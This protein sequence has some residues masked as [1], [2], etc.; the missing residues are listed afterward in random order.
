M[1]T[2]YSANANLFSL[3]LED[4]H[5]IR[6]PAIKLPFMTE[7]TAGSNALILRSR[8]QI[9]ARHLCN[10]L[11]ARPWA[12]ATL[13]LLVLPDKKSALGTHSLAIAIAYAKSSLNAKSSFQ[14][15][16]SENVENVRFMSFG[17]ATHRCS[18][19]G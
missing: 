19:K 2:R 18:G 1:P 9:T 10:I 13:S 4:H 8:A 16:V 11:L 5:P 6:I 7:R 14:E 17:N 15:P 3:A 12:K